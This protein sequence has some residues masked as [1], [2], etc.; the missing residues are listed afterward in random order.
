MF[1]TVFCVAAAA[2]S[3]PAFSAAAGSKYRRQPPGVPA[4]RD[5]IDGCTGKN[6]AAADRLRRSEP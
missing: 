3:C 4:G 5:P 6:D 2:S 1:I